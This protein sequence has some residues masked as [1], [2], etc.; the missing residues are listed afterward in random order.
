VKR[1]HTSQ[2]NV[3]FKGMNGSF[4][5][6]TFAYD[7]NTD[8]WQWMMDDEEGGKPQPFARVKLI[9]RQL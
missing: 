6:T 9:R 4:F 3:D 7:K 2:D 8:T 1:C 5:H